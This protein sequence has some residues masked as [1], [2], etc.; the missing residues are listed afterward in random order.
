MTGP[1]FKIIFCLQKHSVYDSR[2]VNVYFRVT[3]T[4]LVISHSP[5]RQQDAG[6]EWEE[7]GDR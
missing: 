7:D 4:S 2:S 3:F 1:T 5:W 6:G